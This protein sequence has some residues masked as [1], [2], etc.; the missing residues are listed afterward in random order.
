MTNNVRATA[1]PTSTWR[2]PTVLLLLMPFTAVPP[3]HWHLQDAHEFLNWLL[4]EV[5][6]VLEKEERAAQVTLSAG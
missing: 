4:N 5:S 2:Q 3:P 6:E 1:R